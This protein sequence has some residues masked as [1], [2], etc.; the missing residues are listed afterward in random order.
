[1]SQLLFF[2]F[3]RSS[4]FHARES[5]LRQQDVA[6]KLYIFFFLLCFPSL[7]FSS[8]H[9]FVHHSPGSDATTIQVNLY[10][11][12]EWQKTKLTKTA[13]ISFLNT[14]T[15]RL[16][17][18]LVYMSDILSICEGGLRITRSFPVNIERIFFDSYQLQRA[19]KQKKISSAAHSC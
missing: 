12:S 2:F 13:K 4:P 17:W 6:N 5:R 15:A 10:H 8:L 7:S 1:M 3:S 11:S 18:T 16:E 9:T 14:I 19:H